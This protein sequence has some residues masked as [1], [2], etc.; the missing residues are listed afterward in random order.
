MSDHRTDHCREESVATIESKVLLAKIAHTVHSSVTTRSPATLP[1]IN[2]T[3]PTAAITYPT[4]CR[5]EPSNP[6]SSAR[7]SV[8]DTP[9]MAKSAPKMIA[10]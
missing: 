8:R 6:H 9:T 10:V 1:S 4:S 5:I 2:A 3:I 7:L